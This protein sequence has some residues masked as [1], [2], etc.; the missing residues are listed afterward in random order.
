MKTIIS[1]CVF[2]SANAFACTGLSGT[3]Q[4]NHELTMAYTDQYAKLPQD[5]YQFLNQ[6]VGN[7]TISFTDETILIENPATTIEIDD[8]T[9]EWGGTS[10]RSAFELIGCTDNSVAG[11]FNI[12]GMDMLTTFHLVDENTYWVYLGQSAQAEAWNTREF[13]TRV[14]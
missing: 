11:K 8:Y 5:T 7:M 3:W 9:I 10:D 14:E 12:N 6:S 1:A 2:V 4:S 13:F